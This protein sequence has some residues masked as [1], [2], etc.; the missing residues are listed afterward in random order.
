MGVSYEELD[1][2]LTGGE[3][4]IGIKEHIKGMQRR[5]QHKRRLPPIPSF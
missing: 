2:Y 4:D 1:T 3:V 5:S